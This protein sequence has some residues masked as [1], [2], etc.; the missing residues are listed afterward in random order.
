MQLRESWTLRGTA[1]RRGLAVSHF[2]KVA[3]KIS[4]QRERLG[5]FWLLLLEISVCG[6]L[7]LLLWACSK[8]VS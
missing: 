7:A 5:F 8:A 6:P 3:Q 2:N 1:F 4:F